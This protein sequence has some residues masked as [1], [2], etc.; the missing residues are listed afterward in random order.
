A[1]LIRTGTKEYSAVDVCKQLMHSCG[2]D[3]N[4][5]AKMSVNEISKTKGVGK[6]KAITIMA[7]LELG[8]RRKV[9]GVTKMEKIT[10]SSNVFDLLQPSLVDEDQ[11]HFWVIYLNQS[12]KIISTEHLSKGG[13]AGTVVDSRLIFKKALEQTAVSIILCHNH[14]SGNTQPSEADIRLTKKIKEAGN[15]LDIKVLDHI[16]IAGDSYYSFADEGKM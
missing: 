5:L 10:G 6:V 12:N 7:A 14:P 3:F 11:E 16:I 13:V 1:I 15:M 9:N 4:K 8:R 2:N